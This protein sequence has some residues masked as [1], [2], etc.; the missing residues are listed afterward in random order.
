MA[1]VFTDFRSLASKSTKVSLLCCEEQNNRLDWTKEQ[2]QQ[3]DPGPATLGYCAGHGGQVTLRLEEGQCQLC[4][5]CC[6][7]GG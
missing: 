7:M 5:L 1:M 2:V 3:R 4:H 6:L